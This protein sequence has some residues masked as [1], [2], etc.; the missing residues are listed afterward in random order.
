MVPLLAIFA[1]Y[2][3]IEITKKFFSSNSIVLCVI[4]LFLIKPDFFTLLNLRNDYMYSR[5]NDDP[6]KRMFKN[7]GEAVYTDYGPGA[8]VS[9][10]RSSPAYYAR[11]KPFYYIKSEN[12][13]LQD[14]LKYFYDNHVDYI[15]AAKWEVYQYPV[16]QPLLDPKLK[17]KHWELIYIDPK[18]PLNEYYF[19][20]EKTNVVATVWKRK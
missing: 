4:M 5:Y 16:L 12:L 9:V 14:T 6:E 10:F 13:D 2:F 19:A 8:T 15:V 18:I 11:G 7:T 1:A 17:L 3:I 20:E